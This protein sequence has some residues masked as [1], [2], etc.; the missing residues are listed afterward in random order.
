MSADIDTVVVGA[1]AAGLMVARRLA[2]RGTGHVVL[3]DHARVG[4]PWRARYRSLRL[5]T[6]RSLAELPGL[7]LEVGFFAFPTGAQFG[8]YL[9]RYADTFAIPVRSGVRVM[10]LTRRTDGRFVLALSTG[11][12]L[13]ASRVIVAVGAHGIPVR[14]AFAQQLAPGI[15]QLHS[16]EYA[17][18]EQFADGGVLVVGAANSGTDI[19]LEAAAAGHA[20]TIAGR[21]PGQVP[22]DI[23]NPIGNLI[24]RLFIRRLVRT[25]IDT[26]AGRA[27]RAASRGHGVNLVRNTLRDL[28]RAGIVQTARVSGVDASGRPCLADGSIVDAATVVWCTGSRPDLGWIDIAGALEETGLPR[29]HRG[30]CAAVPGL[31]FVGMPFQYSIA[32]ST[33]MGMGVDAD[34]VVEQLYGAVAMPAATAAVG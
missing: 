22:G 4:D 34:Y 12:E 2:L 29:E 32:S 8:D 16:A 19:A 10:R 14:P 5:F 26:E 7:R 17:G 11:E 31:A 21:H 24:A 30:I 15:R 28:R 20:T 3:D 6:P 27:I 1:G 33:L 23:D 13:I 18:P 25:T 9:Q